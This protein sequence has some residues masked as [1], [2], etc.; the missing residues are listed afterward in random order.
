[1]CEKRNN[2]IIKSFNVH[3]DRLKIPRSSSSFV[4]GVAYVTG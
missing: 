4:I 3:F 1:M 2:S